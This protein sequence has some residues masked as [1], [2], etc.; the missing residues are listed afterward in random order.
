VLSPAVTSYR[1]CKEQPALQVLG[2]ILTAPATT[3]RQLASF[4]RLLA[5]VSPAVLKSRLY[6]HSLYEVAAG[7]STWDQ[8]SG[9]ASHLFEP[10]LHAA[11]WLQ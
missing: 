8:E 9:L 5:S 11:G 1:P 4:A 2:G 10:R 7:L 3:K 6:L